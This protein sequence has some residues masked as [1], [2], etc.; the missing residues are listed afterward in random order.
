MPGCDI[1]PGVPLK[2]IKAFF[3]AGLQAAK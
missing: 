3:T 2:N 1:P